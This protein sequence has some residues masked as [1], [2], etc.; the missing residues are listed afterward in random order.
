MRENGALGGR[1]FTKSGVRESLSV[2][3]GWFCKKGGLP[4]NLCVGFGGGLGGGWGVGGVG[5][6][7]WGLGCGFWGFFLGG[8]G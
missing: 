4:Q 1:G 2:G 8:G 5:V 6:F 3:W 7:G